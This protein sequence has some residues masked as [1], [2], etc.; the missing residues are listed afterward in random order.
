MAPAITAEEIKEIRGKYGL[1]QKSF[2]LLL[3]IGPASMVRYEQGVQPSKA[4][5]N[6]IRA[7]RYPEFMKECLENDGELIPK[8]QRAVAERITYAMV[9]FDE[10]TGE[11]SFID[12][13]PRVEPTRTMDEVYHY[14]LQQE[15]LN[16][17]AAN[18]I[19][20]LMQSML[21]DNDVDQCDDSP[22][23]ILL[24]QLYEVKRSIISE[25]SDND[26]FLEQVRGYLRYISTFVD[27]LCM[28][29]RG[30][31]NGL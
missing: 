19:A 14:T 23:R 11:A 30:A 6:L 17:Q 2:A 28:S 12:K 5:A 16:E 9:K 24:K 22:K 10:E 31:R 18:L 7:A 20:D 15:I 13:T 21:R 4:N 3:G 26:A 8:R 29:E 1:S 27:Q 25:Q